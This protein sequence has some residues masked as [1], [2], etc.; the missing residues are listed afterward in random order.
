[1][2]R[3][4]S[5]HQWWWS[6]WSQPVSKQ[7]SFMTEKPFLDNLPIIY[8]PWKLFWGKALNVMSIC[9]TYL[10]DL[11]HRRCVP[12]RWP[13]YTKEYGPAFLV[14]WPK[15]TS[16]WLRSFSFFHYPESQY[17]QHTLFKTSLVTATQS[18]RSLITLN[19]PR[20]FHLK[21]LTRWVILVNTYR[22]TGDCD[23][24]IFQK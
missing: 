15:L 16:F 7:S 13:P 2:A 20:C 3:R 11:L 8:L 14:A 21:T 4:R 24:K 23:K 18:F 22:W 17:L 1:M 19:P 5:H 9:L 6:Q 10:M 12:K